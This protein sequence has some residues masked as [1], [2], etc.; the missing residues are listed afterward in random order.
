MKTLTLKS[1]VLLMAGLLA[2][3]SAQAQNTVQQSPLTPEHF[4]ALDRN[5]SGGVSKEEYEVFMRESFQKMDKNGDKRLTPAETSDV[6]TAEQFAAVDA[7]KDGVITLDEF[8]EH[9]MR[10]FDR[11]DYDKDGQLK[12]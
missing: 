11:Y 7:N 1:A 9:V 10:D 4:A 2:L 12:P 6:L 3:G 8:I 5:K